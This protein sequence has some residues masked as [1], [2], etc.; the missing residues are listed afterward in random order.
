VPGGDAY[1]V[2]RDGRDITPPLRIEGSQKTWTDEV[3]E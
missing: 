3:P 1:I 2:V